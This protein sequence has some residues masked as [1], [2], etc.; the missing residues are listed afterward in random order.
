MS[1]NSQDTRRENRP[2]V[3]LLT[4]HDLGQHLGCYG[5]ETVKT[6]NIDALAAEGLRFE[7]A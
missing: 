3:V 6:P 1:V 4:A 5:I 7:N 2:N